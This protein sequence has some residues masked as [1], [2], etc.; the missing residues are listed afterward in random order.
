[1]LLYDSAPK[2]TNTI[3]TMLIMMGR[4]MDIS[5]RNILMTFHSIRYMTGNGA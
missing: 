4:F 1:M 5:E 2:K 3:K